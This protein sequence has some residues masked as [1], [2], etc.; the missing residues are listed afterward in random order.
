MDHGE[1]PVNIISRHNSLGFA[2]GNTASFNDK[3]ALSDS[4]AEEVSKG[5]RPSLTSK[6]SD[7]FLLKRPPISINSSQEG[8]AELASDTVIRGKHLL[9]SLPSEGPRWEAGGHPANQSSDIQTPGKKDVHFRRISSVSDDTDV[10][11]PSFID[12]LKSN[13]KKPVQPESAAAAGV[14]ELSEGSQASRSAKKK[15]KKG[16]QIDP[17]LLGFKVTSNRIMMGEIQRVDD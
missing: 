12:M 14:S 4:F 5:R 15:V 2:G 17:A 8:L 7:N 16:K 6:G 13:A 10:S 1:T 9:S 3:A 11:E